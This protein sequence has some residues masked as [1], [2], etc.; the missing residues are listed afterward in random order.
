MSNRFLNEVVDQNGVDTEDLQRILD[1]LMP[2][3]PED[4]QKLIVKIQVSRNSSNNKLIM[5]YA[6]TEQRKQYQLQIDN[7]EKKELI[8]IAKKYITEGIFDFDCD[9]SGRCNYAITPKESSSREQVQQVSRKP[10]VTG[11]DQEENNTQTTSNNNPA[12]AT[13]SSS[14]TQ[15]PQQNNDSYDDEDDYDKPK[16]QQA[17]DVIVDPVFGTLT[18]TG[19]YLE[20]KEIVKNVWGKDYNINLRVQTNGEPITNPQRL[21]FRS[22]QKHLPILLQKGPNKLLEFLIVRYNQASKDSSNLTDELI[23]K[24]LR[25]IEL[26]FSKDGFKWGIIFDADSLSEENLCMLINLKTSR[27][28]ANYAVVLEG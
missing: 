26:V 27:V 11:R 1:I 16:I 2:A 23:K 21:A 19:T 22:Y 12:P 9:T 7:T 8:D 13:S 4:W 15:M 25:P 10:A 18:A 14:P 3:A 24:S 6:I 17:G 20:R 5:V 28:E